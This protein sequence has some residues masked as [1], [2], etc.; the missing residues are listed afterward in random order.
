[1]KKTLHKNARKNIDNTKH[2]GKIVGIVAEAMPRDMNL[3]TVPLNKKI[4]KKIGVVPGDIIEVRFN[5]KRLVATVIDGYKKDEN[6]SYIRLDKSSRKDLGIIL[7]EQV[8]VFKPK[9]NEAKV[10]LFEPSRKTPRTI[11]VPIDWQAYFRQKLNNKGV[12]EGGRISVRIF[13]LEMDFDVV[14]ILPDEI[15]RITENTNFDFASE[16]QV[17]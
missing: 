15:G 3:N 12:V 16:K 1:M 11:P 2:G 14:R 9:I 8:D 7:G 17:S 10:V 6:T 13:G 5:E 4:Q